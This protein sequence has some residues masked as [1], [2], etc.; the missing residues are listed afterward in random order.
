[1]TYADDRDRFGLYLLLAAGLMA[2]FLLFSI[3]SSCGA[4]TPPAERERIDKS[5]KAYRAIINNGFT[6]IQLGGT[7]DVFFSECGQDDSFLSSRYFT[8]VNPAGRR[9]S[10]AVCCGFVSKACTIRF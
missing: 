5:S 4:P 10:G 2:T 7:V 6:D 3:F 9:V 1:M 8:A